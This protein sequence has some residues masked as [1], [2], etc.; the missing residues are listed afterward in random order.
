MRL[1]D[2][3]NAADPR[4]ERVDGLARPL[5]LVY[6]ERLSAWVL[7][8][9]PEA[10]E[11]LRLAARCQHLRRWEIPRASYPMNRAGYLKWRADLKQFHARESGRILQQAGYDETMVERVQSLNLKKGFPSDPE[12]RVLED[13]L[14]L[15]FLEHQLGDLAAKTDDDR[16]VNALRKSWEKMTDG[17]RQE[18]LKLGLGERER[19]LLERALAPEVR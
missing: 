4:Q 16:V 14:C 5:D 13:A 6:A 12:C 8:L 11:A 7:R 18:A 3:A 1:L 2:E 17:A 10:S 19:A 15:V 9:C